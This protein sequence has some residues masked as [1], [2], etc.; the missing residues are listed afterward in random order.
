MS[1]ETMVTGVLVVTVVVMVAAVVLTIMGAVGSLVGWP[2]S[3]H[4]R[5]GGA[6]A[7]R[8]VMDT[9]RRE[10]VPAV[11]GG[12]AVGV[13]V[14]VTVLLVG[15]VLPVTVSSHHDQVH[16][17]EC[18]DD[19]ADRDCAQ[20]VVWPNSEGDWVTF[21]ADG[22]EQTVPR[23]RVTFVAADSPEG[24]GRVTSHESCPPR[25]LGAA[26]KNCNTWWSVAVTGGHLVQNDDHGADELAQDRR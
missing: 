26:E 24:Y 4:G 18:L 5:R 15:P 3:P 9:T 22:A 19:G 10:V 11:L 17:L 13:A 12:V 16:E 25:K 2:F 6:G 21:R 14:S 20:V 23:G 1:M 7:S 8:F